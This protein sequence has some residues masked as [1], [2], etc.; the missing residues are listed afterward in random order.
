MNKCLTAG[1]IGFLVGIKCRRC[2]GKMCTA[3][4]KKK[5]MKMMGLK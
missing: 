1:M 4:L 2:M 3:Q 5:A